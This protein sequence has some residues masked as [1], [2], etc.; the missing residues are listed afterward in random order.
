MRIDTFKVEE[1]MNEY[2][3][4]S[5]YDLGNTTVKTLSLN[6]LFKLTGE[7]KTAFLNNL[8]AQ[9][10][11]Y[12][13]IKGNPDFT[14]E[15]AKLYKK[16]VPENIIPTIGAAGANHLVFYSLVEPN[17]KIISFIPTYQQLYSIPASLGAEVQCLKLRKENN[18]LPDTNEFKKLVTPNTKLICINNPNNPTG[19]VI[20]KD[21]LDEI[22]QIANSVG[23]YILSDEVYRGLGDSTVLS[24]A[25]LYENAI[26]VCSMSKLF[27]LAGVR[28]GWIASQNKD[29]IKTCFSHREYNMISC[30]VADETIAA[31]A[32]KHADKILKRN[33]KTV[34]E[35]LEILDNWVNEQEHFSYIKPQGGTTALVYY[36]FDITSDVLCDRLAKEKGI[37]LT[38][39]F[40]FEDEHCFRV[41]FCKDTDILRQ[42]LGKISEFV[43]ENAVCIK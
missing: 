24:L 21:M 23:A 31:L 10:F 22:V 6:E 2:E 15:A 11:G 12:G 35:C 25:D 20:P 39:G 1:W 18:F 4:Y 34:K 19:A 28:L 42:G 13:F 30:S 8:C 38:P 33:N 27:S 32:L 37:F 26:S 14:L 43:R 9:K 41:G 7:D 17:D 16:I 3:Q 29:V 36:D 40:C 5:K